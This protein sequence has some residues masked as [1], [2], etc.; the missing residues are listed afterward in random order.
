MKKKVRWISEC[1]ENFFKVSMIAV[2]ICYEGKLKF[3]KALSKAKVG[4]I[5]IMIKNK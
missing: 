1:E 3:K 5:K 2:G 4:L